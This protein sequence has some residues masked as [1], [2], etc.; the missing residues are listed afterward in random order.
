MPSMLATGD[1]YYFGA[2]GLP[3]DQVRALSYYENAARTGDATGLCAAA[4]MYL[5]GEG[6][7]K[8]VSKAITMYE[9]AAAKGSVKALN[10][11][12]FVYFYG[13]ELPKNQ[14]GYD[15]INHIILASCQF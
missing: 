3:R 15:L 10:G 4:A 11:L 5:K 1:L 2:R 9:E 13:Q 14:V 8:N 12:G 7:P 6:T